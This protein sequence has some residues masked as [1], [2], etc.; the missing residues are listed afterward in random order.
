[1]QVKN[2]VKRLK[3]ITVS[4]ANSI[5]LHMM[6]LNSNWVSIAVIVCIYNDM[7]NIAKKISLEKRQLKWSVRRMLKKQ[8]LTVTHP[9]TK[10]KTTNYIYDI[11]NF[12]LQ[13]N[14]IVKSTCRVLRMKIKMM[15]QTMVMMNRVQMFHKTKKL[16]MTLIGLLWIMSLLEMVKILMTSSDSHHMTSSDSR[17]WIVFLNRCFTLYFL[18]F[19][20]LSNKIN[21]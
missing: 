11:N 16:K 21:P 8:S 20:F 13:I 10:Y 2:F 18:H 4:Y 6:M 14:L 17:R 7:F 3:Y 12:S 5:C 19:F 1:M 9:S 15:L